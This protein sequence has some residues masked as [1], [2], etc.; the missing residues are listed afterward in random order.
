MGLKDGLDHAGEHI[1]A[2]VTDA[3][4]AGQKAVS[5]IGHAADEARHRAAAAGEH[6]KQELMGD[7][8]TESEKAKSG[9]EEAKQNVQADVAGAKKKLDEL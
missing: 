6:D 8:L 3:V 7:S 5:Q 2:A 1:K 9:F 4:D